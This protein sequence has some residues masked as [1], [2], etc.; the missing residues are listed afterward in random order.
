MQSNQPDLSLEQARC[1]DEACDR[2][3]AAWKEG[4][5]PRIE[6]YLA[7]AA[8]GIQAELLKALLAVELELVSRQSALP[9][10]R[11]CQERFPEHAQIVARIYGDAAQRQSRAVG[12]PSLVE[13]IAH[14]PSADDTSHLGV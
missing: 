7:D 13:T 1:L 9:P 2:F 12:P 6:A 3:E 8:T 14:A 11:R 10:L 4:Q 5:R